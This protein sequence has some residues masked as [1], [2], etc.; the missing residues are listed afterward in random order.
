MLTDISVSGNPALAVLAGI[1]F[2]FFAMTGFENT[3]NVAEE[4]VDPHRSFPRSLVGGMVVAGTVYVLVSMAAALTVPVDQ[5]ANSDAALLEVVKQGILPFSTDGMTTLF[6]VIALIAITNTTLVTIVTQP[7]ILYGMAKEDVVPGVFATI[8]A[9]R[10]SP[11]VGLL[12]SAAVVAGL[13]IAGTVLLEAGGGIDLVNRLALVTVVLLLAIYA[14]VIV[15]CL[16]LRGR[17]ED[18]RTFRANTPL[19]IVGLVGNLAILGFSIYDDPSSL[20]WCAALIAVGV[21]L[22]LI[23]YAVG[24]RNRPPGA[25]RGDPETAA[26]TEV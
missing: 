21:V 23:E 26:R 1:A 4:T 10:R 7:R 13:L 12:F 9:T 8:H 24:S 11:W 16:K 17:D 22:F 18:E 20:I 25:E 5:L 2:S 14:L 3:A 15:A 19:L 6:S